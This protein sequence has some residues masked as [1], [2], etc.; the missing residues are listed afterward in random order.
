[1]STPDLTH[2]YPLSKHQRYCVFLVQATS[3]G[4]TM[5]GNDVWFGRDVTVMPGT[6]ADIAHHD[7]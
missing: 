6:P 1:L 7:C 3:K 4:D 5:V 2:P